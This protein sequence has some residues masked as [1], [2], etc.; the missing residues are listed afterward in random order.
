MTEG[1]NRGAAGRAEAAAGGKAEGAAGGK[2]G[3]AA[4]GKAEGAAGG[5]AGGAA[6]GKAG[7]AAGG[8]TGAGRNA[9]T[10]VEAGAAAKEGP[11]RAGAA[12]AGI[13][14]AG[15]P[16]VCDLRSRLGLIWLSRGVLCVRGACLAS[17]TSP[18]FSS[19]AAALNHK[20]RQCFSMPWE[21]K[22]LVACRITSKL[23]K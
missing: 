13:L 18:P 4:G 11:G 1:P 2:A 19:P 20:G 22:A 12:V 23:V 17:T 8:T 6:G 14:G 9:G 7:G 3:G 15:R 21:S 5:K 16:G 10:A